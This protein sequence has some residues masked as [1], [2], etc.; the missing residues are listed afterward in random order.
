MYVKHDNIVW[1]SGQ[2]AFCSFHSCDT[3]SRGMITHSPTAIWPKIYSA[4]LLF[5][6]FCISLGCRLFAFWDR[7]HRTGSGLPLPAASSHCRPVNLP[8]PLPAFIKDSRCHRKEFEGSLLNNVST[9]HI[10]I[11]LYVACQTRL[12]QSV[13]LQKT[14]FQMPKRCTTPLLPFH[15]I[16]GQSDDEDCGLVLSVPKQPWDEES[17]SSSP[18]PTLSTPMST[19]NPF[20]RVGM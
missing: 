3:L 14:A 6:D 9:A 12:R 19:S 2:F 5:W 16:P 13:R 8:F 20:D 11:I 10:L 17:L 7:L 4:W 18:S 1:N 15:E